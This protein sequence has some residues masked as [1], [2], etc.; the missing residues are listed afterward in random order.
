MSETAGERTEP[1]RRL[2]AV[3]GIRHPNAELVEILEGL[4]A[5]AK[6]GE[7]VGMSYVTEG[8]SG[9]I[10]TGYTTRHK[11]AAIG[12]LRWLE[13]RMVEGVGQ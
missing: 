2:E 6:A 8:L 3:M 11:L 7:V 4:L 5:R 13:R 12:G 9:D 10:G 1:P